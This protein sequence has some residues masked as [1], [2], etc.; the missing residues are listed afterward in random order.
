ML[1]PCRALNGRHPDISQ[2]ARGAEH[3]RRRLAYM[4][5][6]ES[7]ERDFKAYREPLENVTVFR[8]LGRVLTLGDNDWLAV[9]GN[10]GKAKKS[11]G[12]VIVDTDPGGGRSVSVRT[13][14]KSS[15]AGGVS[16]Q[17]GD[18]GAH[19]EDGAGPG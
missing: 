10:L 11:W 12:A 13:F 18:V 6:R 4:E 19:P 3:K 5:M 8:Y 16:V 17:V 15:G 7:L 1:V 9:V 14:L 2:C